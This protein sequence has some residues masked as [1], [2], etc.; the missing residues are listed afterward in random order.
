MLSI[1]WADIWANIVAFLAVIADPL[2]VTTD[3]AIIAGVAMGA[4]GIAVVV[5]GVLIVVWQIWL[6]RRTTRHSFEGDLNREYR[7]IRQS[8]PMDALT[9]KSVA[10]LK[11][12]AQ[13][14]IYN[15]LDLCNQQVYLRKNW[16]IGWSCWRIW[17]EGIKH[18]LS[19]PA[20]AKVWD[21]VRR[22]SPGSL[23]H[24]ERLEKKDFGDPIFWILTAW[25]R[26]SE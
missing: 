1:P 6:L 12:E 25:K 26:D 17:K 19:Q 20:I 22:R 21:E 10:G 13:E 4:L 18:H 2:A 3:M 16:R 24:L 8:I 9:G 23:S 11:P 5:G 15:Y 14:C 7:A